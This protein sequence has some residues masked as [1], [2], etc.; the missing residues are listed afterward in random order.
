[1]VYHTTFEAFGTTS[2][3]QVLQSLLECLEE[4]VFAKM[5]CPEADVRDLLGKEGLHI[6]LYSESG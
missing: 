4:K 6:R 1:M 3:W 5:Q 2:T